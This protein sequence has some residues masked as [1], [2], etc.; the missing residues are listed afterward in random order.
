MAFKSNCDENLI[1]LQQ[2]CFG[3]WLE[4]LFSLD[5]S[6]FSNVLIRPGVPRV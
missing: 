2:Y 3:Y 6:F 4:I 5:A 1:S